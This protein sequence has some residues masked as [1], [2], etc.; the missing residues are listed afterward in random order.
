MVH[1]GKH[2]PLRRT[3]QNRARHREKLTPAQCRPSSAD[4]PLLQFLSIVGDKLASGFTCI[5]MCV[6]VVQAGGRASHC[7]RRQAILK[8]LAISSLPAPPWRRCSGSPSTANYLP[9]IPGGGGLCM[10]RVLSKNLSACIGF[11]LALRE[12]PHYAYVCMAMMC[13]Y[14][15]PW[16][17]GESARLLTTAVKQRTACTEGHVDSAALLGGILHCWTSTNTNYPQKI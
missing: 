4:A 7:K 6:R 15:W 1:S 14:A 16:C 11:T 2:S 12:I 9:Q 10:R 8:G 17:I 13:M 3:L 5:F